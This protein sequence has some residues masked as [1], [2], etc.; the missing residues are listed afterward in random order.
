MQLGVIGL[1]R[2]GTNM[3]RRLMKAGHQCVVYDVRP[4]AVQALVKEGAA[5]T[6]SLEGFAKTL[7]KPRAVWLMVPAAV[8]DSTL[9]TLV[10]LLERDDVVIDGGNSYY[11]DDIRRAAEL[12]IERHS[13]PGRRDQWRRLGLGAGL[14][15]DDRR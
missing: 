4:G 14:L 7:E 12:E 10:P 8:V 5:G 6:T 3:A 9:K 15:P 1:G 11:H 13:I 2:M